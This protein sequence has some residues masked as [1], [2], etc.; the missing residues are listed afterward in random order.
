MKLLKDLQQVI[1]NIWLSILRIFSPRDDDYPE[2]GV[3]P[4]EGEPYDGN[5]QSF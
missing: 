5:Q 3:Q 1:Q 4:F 2:T